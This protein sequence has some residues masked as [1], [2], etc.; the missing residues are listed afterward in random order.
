MNFFFIDDLKYPNVVAY[1][2]NNK[3]NFKLS[4][5]FDVCQFLEF[6]NHYNV[7]IIT[8]NGFNRLFF[9]IGQE[10]KNDS[11][12][13][14]RVGT[15][16]KNGKVFDSVHFFK[17]IDLAW[18]VDG[19]TPE[20]WM[21]GEAFQIILSLL[22][23]ELMNFT[24]LSLDPDRVF[25]GGNSKRLEEVY[26]TTI[27]FH[28]H[29]KNWNDVYVYSLLSIYIKV[30][31][32]D[33]ENKWRVD[34]L[35][36]L[37]E[38][39]TDASIRVAFFIVYNYI[40]NSTKRYLES[41]INTE[42]RRLI[43]AGN[44]VALLDGF[45]IRCNNDSDDLKMLK[46]LEKLRIH[47]VDPINLMGKEEDGK[48]WLYGLDESH[49]NDISLDYISNHVIEER[50]INMDDFLKKCPH[51]NCK[52]N[53]RGDNL[54]TN[55]RY[56]LYKSVTINDDIVPLF[57]PHPQTF[58][59]LIFKKLH[60]PYIGWLNNFLS[61][62][63]DRVSWIYKIMSKSFDAWKSVSNS[64]EGNEELQFIDSYNLSSVTTVQHVDGCVIEQFN[65][66]VL[67]DLKT[68]YAK[69]PDIY[70][71]LSLLH[72]SKS[73]LNLLSH[74]MVCGYMPN[75]PENM[76]DL[77]KVPKKSIILHLIDRGFVCVYVEEDNLSWFFEDNLIKF[78]MCI[79]CFDSN[80]GTP[81][82][83]FS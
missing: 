15:C 58:G 83:F 60:D 29:K 33:N 64:F 42:I 51:F 30:L 53:L 12:D 17:N 11:I 40:Q 77:E 72:D 35:K 50:E 69:H 4:H 32:D 80:K 10:F 76:T 1:T 46:N 66:L 61:K 45:I 71:N 5:E 47:N 36:S 21:F 19:V 44:I 59:N 34:I 7:P 70:G 6:L 55:Y 31:E 37:D 22:K 54:K 39:N 81:A 38:I 63:C 27:I 9:K 8:Q 25:N 13:Y 74:L 56:D 73:F 20:K 43:P 2:E 49:Y 62:E 26:L 68:G 75:G 65:Q 23:N 67:Y 79:K 41:K 28:P 48:I 16:L 82:G 78:V 3:Y 24:K 18:I 57:K 52:L 14:N